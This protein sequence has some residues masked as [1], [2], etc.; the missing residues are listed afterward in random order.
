MPVDPAKVSDWAPAPTGDYLHDHDPQGNGLQADG[1]SMP[2]PYQMVGKHGQVYSETPNM[3][4]GFCNG[5]PDGMVPNAADPNIGNASGI[6]PGP[7][8][9]G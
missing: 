1:S 2:Q 8:A 9:K 3:D 5:S 7:F 4:G 6:S